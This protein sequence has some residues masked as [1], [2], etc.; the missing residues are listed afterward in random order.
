VNNGKDISVQ[1]V[2][3]LTTKAKLQMNSKVNI[4]SPLAVSI[5]GRSIGNWQK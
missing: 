4:K 5:L 3:I 1:M 2:E